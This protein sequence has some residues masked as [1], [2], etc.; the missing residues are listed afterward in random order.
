MKNRLEKICT[1]ETT[2]VAVV[3][4]DDG[5]LSRGSNCRDEEMEQIELTGNKK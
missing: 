3:A 4:R 1:L 5:R 2:A